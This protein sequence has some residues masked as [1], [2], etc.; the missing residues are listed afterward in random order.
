MLKPRIPRARPPATAIRSQ[1]GL[2]LVELMV[3]IAVGMFVV[4]GA[5]MVVSAQ[6]GDNRRLLLE[7][8]V[9]QDLRA[10]A[11]IVTREL[12]RAGAQGSSWE[13]VHDA[14]L[15]GARLGTVFG[16]THSAGLDEVGFD[17]QRVAAAGLQTGPWGFRLDRGVI[18]SRI[19]GAWQPLTDGNA[20]LVT[21]FQVEPLTPIVHVVPCPRGCGGNAADETCWPRVTVRGYRIEIEGRAVADA[22]VQRSVRSEV[23]LRNELLQFDP[24]LPPNQACPG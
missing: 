10:T 24:A 9:Q 23:R 1:R 20:L 6:L 11:D 2:S 14:A 17:Y 3:G 8:Q 16:I 22:A 21:R 7:T 4:S 19:G 18:Q 5:A 15:P 12:R 13:Q